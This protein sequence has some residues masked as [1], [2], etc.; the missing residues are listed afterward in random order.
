MTDFLAAAERLL[1]VKKARERLID[2]TELT[3]PLPDGSG[4]RYDAQY[5]HRAL[6]AALEEVEKGAVRRL[7]V[8][9]P[10]RHGKSEL[11]SKRFPAWFIGRNPH[12]SYIFGTY[13]ETFAEDFGRSIRD[14]IES[15]PYKQV[16]PNAALKKG[17]AAAAR[18]ETT[19]DGLMV[20]V[21]RGGSVTGRGGHLI[22]IDDPIK[23]SEEADSATVRDSLWAWY[24]NDILTRLMDE[25]CSVVI[26]QTRWHEDDL[27]GRITDPKNPHYVEEEA[28]KWK[29]FN[30]PALAE[31]NDPLGRNPGEALWP[32][33][34]GKPK[35]GRE[36]LLD[37]KRRNPR[38][39][40][41]LFQQRPTPEDGEF[42]KAKDIRLYNREEAPPVE[43]LRVYAASDHAVALKQHNDKTCI[44]VVGVDS[45]DVIWIL[46][47]WWKRAATDEVVEQIV[48]LV[49]K[50]KPVTWFSDKDHV[51]KSIGP[52]LKKRLREEKAWVT[53]REVQGYQDKQKKAQSIAGRMSMGM[54][55][56]PRFAGWL[57]DARE[58]LLKFPRASHDDFVDALSHLG[59]GLGVLTKA[60]A[61]EVRDDGPKVGSFGWIKESAK[62]REREER[63]AFNMDTW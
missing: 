43:R 20:F 3:M 8:T 13:N 22:V 42:F 56:F 15:K 41:A 60:P 12:K 35:F 29:I 19:Y 47:V 55:M 11:T 51:S 45:A 9:F 54:V 25:T 1:A 57:E 49:K 31:D 16:F 62:Q 5:F 7:I 14:I 46:D 52:F 36:Y 26:I 32:T 50:W 2:F 44:V 39:F 27:V 59:L 30:V 23:N 34:N 4:T 17:S 40:S 63:I 61:E 37:I 48:K 21:G 38:G 18:L 58:E 24:Q 10:P 53:F 6:A 28:A 33:A